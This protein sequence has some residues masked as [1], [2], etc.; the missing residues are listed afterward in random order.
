MITDT[1]TKLRT[2]KEAVSWGYA[3]K[4]II[5]PLVI[6]RIN[7]DFL[8]DMP[9]EY[10]RVNFFC[11]PSESGPY[12]LCLHYVPNVLGNIYSHAPAVS[13]L[14]RALSTLSLLAFLGTRRWLDLGTLQLAQRLW[15]IS[16][17]G[18]RAKPVRQTLDTDRGRP[19]LLIYLPVLVTGPSVGGIV[20]ETAMSLAAG[21]PACIILAGRSLPKVHQLIDRISGA[22]QPSKLN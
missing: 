19:L 11:K 20:A 1:V 6:F 5:S 3:I 18:S 2:T 10:S 15:N 13:L 16:R 22:F 7:K 9:G 4:S 12:V 14:F 17:N 21:S 8:F